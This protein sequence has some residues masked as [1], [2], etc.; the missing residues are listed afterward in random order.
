VPLDGT[1][2]GD[3][4]LVRRDG[5]E[6]RIAAMHYLEYCRQVLMLS[7]EQVLAAAGAQAMPVLNKMKLCHVGEVLDIL[8]SLA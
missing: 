2:L 3:V 5:G 6:D 1:T 8:T 7:D 4:H